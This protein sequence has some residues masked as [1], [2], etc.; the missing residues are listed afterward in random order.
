FISPL[1][2]SYFALNLGKADNGFLLQSLSSLVPESLSWISL[3]W[4]F[5]I[6]SLIMVIVILLSK[7]PKVEL[8]KD[9]KAGAFSVFTDL[10]KKPIVWLFFL[11][12]FCYE[13]TEQGVANWIS[14]FLYEYHQYD[15]QTTGAKA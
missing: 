6:I 3:Y 8:D 7:F 14:Q 4:L 2:Y 12:I 13:G 15:P 1:V 5:A 10:L 9:E 11:A